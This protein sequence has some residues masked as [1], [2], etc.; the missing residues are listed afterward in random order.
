V[1]DLL[2]QFGIR[3]A[4]KRRI[5]EFERDLV[6]IFT[7]FSVKEFRKDIRQLYVL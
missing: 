5:D 2:V 1:V 4:L 7:T 3:E 6:G